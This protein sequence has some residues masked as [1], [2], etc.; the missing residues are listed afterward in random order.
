MDI[1]G[2]G[3]GAL[4][5]QLYEAVQS[6]RAGKGMQAVMQLDRPIGAVLPRWWTGQKAS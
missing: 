5:H 2:D 3:M 4:V 1:S 6:A